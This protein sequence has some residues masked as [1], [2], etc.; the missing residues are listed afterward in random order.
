MAPSYRAHPRLYRFCPSQ[1][2]SL[3]SGRLPRRYPGLRRQE[4][5]TGQLRLPDRAHALLWA[6]QARVRT[7]DLTTPRDKLE[8]AVITIDDAFNERRPVAVS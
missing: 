8:R 5:E 7:R 6:R 3:K 1:P 4:V 2:G